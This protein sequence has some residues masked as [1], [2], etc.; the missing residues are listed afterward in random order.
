MASKD[1][2]EYLKNGL[3]L[4]E[5]EIEGGEDDPASHLDASFWLLALGMIVVAFLGIPLP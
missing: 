1:F 4:S 2:T 3:G 5:S